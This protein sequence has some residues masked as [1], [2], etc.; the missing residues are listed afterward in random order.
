M[1]LASVKQQKQRLIK[2]IKQR[3][4]ELKQNQYLTETQTKT[5]TKE[6]ENINK[7]TL[8]ELKT[9]SR[10]LNKKNV[11]N[12]TKTRINY[13]L[14]KAGKTKVSLSSKQIQELG[15]KGL[16]EK[17]KEYLEIPATSKRIKDTQ[18][19]ISSGKLSTYNIETTLL[20]KR[21]KD[22]LT[23][24]KNAKIKQA[25]LSDI[26]YLEEIARRTGIAK[27]IG[28]VEDAKSDENV[29]NNLKK[30]FEKVE[31]NDYYNDLLK[32]ADIT[33]YYINNEEFEQIQEE[34]IPFL[35]LMENKK[36]E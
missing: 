6:V 11:E 28:L 4:N 25:S 36:N 22:I 33:Q 5:F 29:M 14:S 19:R 18:E 13:E 17:T 24:V 34:N 21:T 30:Q 12:V 26:Q 3:F 23:A 2:S 9:L 1:I 10:G 7:K 27:Y 8:K 32:S 15:K 20:S 35:E 31:R 16:L